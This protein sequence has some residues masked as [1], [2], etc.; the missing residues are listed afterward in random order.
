VNQKI[1]KQVYKLYT[2]NKE[3]RDL[4]KKF[5]KFKNFDLALE[6]LFNTYQYPN[7]VQSQFYLHTLTLAKKENMDNIF[8]YLYLKS[9][10]SQSELHGCA[11]AYFRKKISYCST[12][13]ELKIACRQRDTYKK[14]GPEIDALFDNK[15]KELSQSQSPFLNNQ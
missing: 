8:N 14:Y 13:E 2:F 9:I 10:S 15:Q 11:L 4:I 6:C 12:L 7:E 5:Q 1:K 3:D